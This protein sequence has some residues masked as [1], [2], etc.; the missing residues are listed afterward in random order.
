VVFAGG[1]SLEETPQDPVR[2][3][4]REIDDQYE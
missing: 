2:G 4:L 3:P 1:E